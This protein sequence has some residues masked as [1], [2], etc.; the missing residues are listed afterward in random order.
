M[1]LKGE[2]GGS[3][4]TNN[5]IMEIVRSHNGGV[6]S[7]RCSAV[8][9]GLWAG[10]LVT[11][12]PVGMLLKG[13]VGGSNLTNN[14]IMELVRTHNGGVG[15]GALQRCELGSMGR[16]IGD[17]LS[18]GMLLKGEVGGS[19]LTNNLI[20][21]IVRSH[22]GG[23]GVG[24]LQRCHPSFHYSSSSTLNSGVLSGCVPEK[25]ATSS[26]RPTTGLKT[27]LWSELRQ[28]TSSDTTCSKSLSTNPAITT[29]PFPVLWPH[30]HAIANHFPIGHPS[31]HYSS[32]STLNSGVLSECV[33]EKDLNFPPVSN[34]SPARPLLSL[35]DDTS[36]ELKLVPSSSSPF[37]SSLSLPSSSSS[38]QS[39]WTLDKVKSALERAGKDSTGVIKKRKL[40]EDGVCDL[41]AAVSCPVAVGCPGCLSYVLVM[42]N[43]PKC[44][45][46]H[47]FVPL[48]AMKKPK[49]DLNISI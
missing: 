22:N 25:N 30:S 17:S 5:L 9:L 14:L 15:V 2:V 28:L 47:S 8:S 20:M 41:T 21:E 38:F 33:P 13:E 27:P 37:S 44:P 12:C 32:S 24:A 16:S 40:P 4:L 1:L 45:R 11:A 19:N 3:N 39:V 42:K 48:P 26:L 23:V 29:R 34:K 7:V 43:N 31:F 6:G 46:C 10:Q 35:F 49:I 18:C 36:L